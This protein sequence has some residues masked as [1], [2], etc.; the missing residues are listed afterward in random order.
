MRYFPC[1]ASWPAPKSL[2]ALSF[3]SLSPRLQ[4]CASAHSPPRSRQTRTQARLFLRSLRAPLFLA[5]ARALRSG[6]GLSAAALARRGGFGSPPLV[7]ASPRRGR[8]QRPRRLAS[9]GRL[10]RWGLPHSRVPPPRLRV[11]R[12]ASHRRNRRSSARGA[13]A[14]LRVAHWAA[15]PPPAPSS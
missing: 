13:F 3:A 1:P 10:C 5:F 6:G 7:T 15:Q 4:R 8:L 11:A 2:A 12:G 14:P 9:L